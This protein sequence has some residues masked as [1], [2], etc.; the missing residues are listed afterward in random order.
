[1]FY[2]CLLFVFVAG[3]QIICSILVCKGNVFIQDTIGSSWFIYVA[4]EHFFEIF[5]KSYYIIYKF[6][7]WQNL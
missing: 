4:V 1:M 7:L 2:V 3:V 6:E 5:D